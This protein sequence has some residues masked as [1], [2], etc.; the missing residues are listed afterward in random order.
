MKL[1]FITPTH[2]PVWL[3]EVWAA[4]R[5][6]THEDWEWV[7]VCN[8]KGG[9]GWKAER[10]ATEIRPMFEGDARVRVEVDGRP[11][12][13]IGDRKR[14][15]FQL[16]QGDVLI[17]LDHDDLLVSAAG[18]RIASEFEH[19]PDVGFV[20]SDWADFEDLSSDGTIQGRPKSYRGIKRSDWET[21][22]FRFYD[23]SLN[24]QDVVRPGSYECVRGFAPSAAA[25][26]LIFWAPNHVR[27]WR[28]STYHQLGG[29]D[30][31]LAVCDDHD[32][33][34]RTYLATP[35][36]HIPEPLY[37]YRVSESNTWTKQEARI[38]QVT[39]QIKDQYYERLVL[40]E[41]ALR[42]LP[43]YDLGG[44]FNCPAGWTPVDNHPD[45]LRVGGNVVDLTREWPWPDNS[46]G[47]F[48]AFDLLS[49]LPD[50][51]FTMSQLWRCLAPG[52]YLLSATPST[53]GRGAF[54]DPLARSYWNENAF[55][56]WTRKHSAQ[57]IRNQQ[58][59]FQ[60]LD[61]YT[62]YPSDWHTQNKIP[63]VTANLVA[64][65]EEHRGPGAI[66]I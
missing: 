8:D 19:H 48:R 36:R 34:C 24:R 62:G 46:V 30:P 63:Y 64:L 37:L 59:R 3:R 22:G 53:D 43:A 2:N 31:A 11:W 25:F 13:G 6:Q 14:H 4:V 54:Q 26:S 58:V 41:A 49:H 27:A 5:S 38:D 18:Q 39:R 28:R 23:Q 32:L 66:S 60:A 51:I 50:P 1:S 40:R 52:G 56:Y 17:E 35:C 45:V 29:H 21:N 33:M 16:G 10:M 61:L 44:A 9:K 20:Y 15:A 47:A 12:A 65:K 42:W 57:Y 7:I 55:W